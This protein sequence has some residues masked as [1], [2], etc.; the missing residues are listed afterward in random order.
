MKNKSKFIFLGVLLIGLSLACDLPFVDED[1]SL[2]RVEQTRIAKENDD[3]ANAGLTEIAREDMRTEA[4][5]PTAR[6]TAGPTSMPTP[7][8]GWQYFRDASFD[9]LVF[10]GT[11]TEDPVVDIQFITVQKENAAVVK[12]EIEMGKAPGS[13]NN[14]SVVLFLFSGGQPLRAF[15]YEIDDGVKTIGEI[16]PD[17]ESFDIILPT[18]DVEGFDIFVDGNLVVFQFPENFFPDGINDFFVESSHLKSDGES[19]SGD[20][21]DASEP[22]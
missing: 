20:F 7:N 13:E 12:I 18:T 16:N 15:I 14:Y 4:A 8:P 10:G 22:E 3:F 9:E 2:T 19:S 5:R 17:P 1:D 6:P 21:A 11:D